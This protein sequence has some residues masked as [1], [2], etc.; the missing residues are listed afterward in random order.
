MADHFDTSGVF[1]ISR[2]DISKLACICKPIDT[3]TI[4][5]LGLFFDIF[6]PRNIE[7]KILDKK[8]CTYP[9]KGVVR[10]VSVLFT[11]SSAC[12]G[13]SLNGRALLLKL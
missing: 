13:T 2:F 3:I 1:E 12:H 9:D 6:I 5:L 4:C 8:S 10:L 11:I 7:P